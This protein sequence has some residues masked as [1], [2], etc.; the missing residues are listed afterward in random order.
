MGHCSRGYLKLMFR[1]IMQATLSVGP[2]VFI[3]EL[4]H[5]LAV[6]SVKGTSLVAISLCKALKIILDFQ[7]FSVNTGA[8][9]EKLPLH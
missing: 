6:C 5:F 1:N 4:D 9:T 7:L 2:K 8:N 3:V